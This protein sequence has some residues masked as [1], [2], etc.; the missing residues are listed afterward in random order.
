LP[1]ERIVFASDYPQEIRAR[2]KVKEFVDGIRA[3]GAEG[4]RILDE[5]TG[6]LLPGR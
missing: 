4:A 6:L 3:L 2:E 5:S 1:S